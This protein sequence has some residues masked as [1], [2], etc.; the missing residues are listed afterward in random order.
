MRYYWKS[1]FADE[2][3]DALID[4]LVEAF[5]RRPSHHSTIDIWPTAARS[6]ACRRSQR[7]RARDA[8]WLVSPNSNW[9]STADDATN[10]GWAR[11]IVAAVGGS[12]YLNFPGLLEAGDVQASSSHGTTFDQLARVKRAYDPD[13]VFRFN[14]N[15]APASRG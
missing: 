2:L 11:D 13:N 14:A 9:K 4:A 1:S 8:P 10:I 12:A 6:H 15:I 3:S 7:V 5:A